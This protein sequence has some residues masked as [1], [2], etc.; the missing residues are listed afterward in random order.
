MS[1]NVGLPACGAMAV[2][3]AIWEVRLFWLVCMAAASVAV[4]LGGGVSI[5]SR[6]TR[7]LCL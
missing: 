7:R 3:I 5:Y 1:I 4:I 6:P 2:N